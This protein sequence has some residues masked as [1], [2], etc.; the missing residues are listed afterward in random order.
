MKNFIEKLQTLFYQGF[1]IEKEEK[2]KNIEEDEGLWEH[3][4]TLGSPYVLHGDTNF[5]IKKE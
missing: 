1:N 5:V 4:F 2:K 3:D